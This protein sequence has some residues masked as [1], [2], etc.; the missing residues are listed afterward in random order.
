MD[1]RKTVRAVLAAVIAV[2]CVFSL[3]I[4]VRIAGP[5]MKAAV[6]ESAAQRM[7]QENIPFYEAFE[8]IRQNQITDILVFYA[9]QNLYYLPPF[10]RYHADDALAEKMGTMRDAY[11][12]DI[13]YSQTLER[14][15]SA[16]RGDYKIPPNSLP[17]N[18]RLV[19]QGPDARIYRL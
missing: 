10:T 18:A 6:S 7:R 2:N 13:D 17:S 4:V 11:V 12:L 14:N 5:L 3:L 9:P 19:F 1:R 8:F 15:L 16:L